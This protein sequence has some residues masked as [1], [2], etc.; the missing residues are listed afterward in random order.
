MAKFEKLGL[1]WGH[2]MW[3]ESV[4]FSPRSIKF[5]G[6]LYKWWRNSYTKFGAAAR[7]RFFAILKK[8]Q[9][10]GYPPPPPPMRGLK[11]PY[12]LK[13][14]PYAY[15]DCW[16]I[17]KNKYCSRSFSGAVFIFL[18]FP[19]DYAYG[20]SL[21]VYRAFECGNAQIQSKYWFHAHI[22]ALNRPPR[23]TLRYAPPTSI[24]F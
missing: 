12:T 2:L 1:R 18:Y 17:K 7:R 21:Y 20:F 5:S 3:P 11:T 19:T 13:A 10:G 9:G 16:K 4:T 15:R 22:R 23:S 8:P 24:N 14:S 6:D